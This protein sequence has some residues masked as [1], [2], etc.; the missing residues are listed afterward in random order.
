MARLAIYAHFDADRRVRPY[1]LHALQS[2]RALSDRLVFVSTAGL[3]E[4]ELAKVD[5]LVDRSLACENRGYDFAMWQAALRTVDAR[6]YDELVLLNSSVLGPIVPL[7]PIFERMAARPDVDFWGATECTT[8]APHLQSYFLV[9]KTRVLHSEPF[10]AFFESVLPYR[11]K[12][13]VIR[14]YEIGLTRFLV[15]EGFRYDAIVDDRALGRA[16]RRGRLG[17]EPLGPLH[18]AVRTANAWR[19]YFERLNPTLL[20]PIELV[21]LGVPFMKLEHFRTNPLRIRRE[22]FVTALGELG[23]PRELLEDLPR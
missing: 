1:V 2:L 8:F 15:D 5:A 11:D 12:L 18:A 16:L 23:Y 3:P 20:W 19:W 10:R 9:M 13:Q 14:S 22:R 17:R 6:S 21:T 4:G 7:A